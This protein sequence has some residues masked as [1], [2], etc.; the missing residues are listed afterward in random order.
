[1]N[2]Q[3]TAVLVP[4]VASAIVAPLRVHVADARQELL[5]NFLAFRV[6]ALAQWAVAGGRAVGHKA[7][8]GGKQRSDCNAI[9]KA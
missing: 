4:R 1:M 9:R 3:A 2:F 5:A 8:I 7:C 6:P